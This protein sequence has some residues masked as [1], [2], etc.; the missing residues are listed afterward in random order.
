MGKG[1]GGEGARKRERLEGREKEWSGGKS[2]VLG[3]DISVKD[4]DEDDQ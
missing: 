4:D 1:E 3:M 2:L